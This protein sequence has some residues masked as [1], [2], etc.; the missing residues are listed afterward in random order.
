MT[1]DQVSR[2]FWITIAFI[3]LVLFGNAV[4]VWWKRR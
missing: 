1:A 3:P 4:W 2:L